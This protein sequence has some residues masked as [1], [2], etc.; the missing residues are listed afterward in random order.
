MHNVLKHNGQKYGKSCWCR[1]L[2][3]TSKQNRLS[4]N[5]FAMIFKMNNIS[6][7]TTFTASELVRAPW[8]L[9]INLAGLKSQ[10]IPLN[11]TSLLELKR[12]PLFEPKV[13]VNSLLVGL[14]HVKYLINLVFSVIT[15]SYRT[16]FFSFFFP[17]RI[18]QPHRGW[19]I[20][21]SGKNKVCSTVYWP[22]IRSNR[23]LHLC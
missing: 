5:A 2:Q 21:S 9:I 8:L 19:A 22:R 6:D 23:Y 15:V 13:M 10:Y 12:P 7:L 3:A 20:N 11:W 16:L 18:S 4:E 1:Y 17:A 14:S